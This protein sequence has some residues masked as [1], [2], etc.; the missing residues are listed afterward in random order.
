MH[1]NLELHTSYTSK[2]AISH[3]IQRKER[4]IVLK[5]IKVNL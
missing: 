3:A 5:K 2:F 1:P 4:K